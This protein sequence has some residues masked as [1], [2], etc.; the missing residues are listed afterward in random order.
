MTVW[1]LH[2]NTSYVDIKLATQQNINQIQ[3]NLNTSYVDIKPTNKLFL[4]L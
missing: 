3:S 2:L 1:E 4:R